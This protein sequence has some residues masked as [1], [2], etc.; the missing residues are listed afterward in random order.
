MNVEPQAVMPLLGKEML[1]N[2]SVGPTSWACCQERDCER[3]L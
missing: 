2:S 3:A 1:G